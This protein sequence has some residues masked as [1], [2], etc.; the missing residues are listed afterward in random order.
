MKRLFTVFLVFAVLMG[1]ITCNADDND[2]AVSID[3]EEDEN[4]LVVEDFEEPVEEV[5]FLLGG[6]LPGEVDLSLEEDTFFDLGGGEIDLFTPEAQEDVETKEIEATNIAN[7][8]VSNG[9]KCP[10]SVFYV[11]L[12]DRHTSEPYGG[13]IPLRDIS[14]SSNTTAHL[15]Q[16]YWSEYSDIMAIY[17]GSVYDYHDSYSGGA[18]MYIV[19][20]HNIDGFIFYSEYQHLSSIEPTYKTKGQAVQAGAKIATKGGSGYGRSDG[21]GQHL[22]LIIASGISRTGQLWTSQFSKYT[23]EYGKEDTYGVNEKSERSFFIINGVTY[24]NPEKILN[25]NYIIGPRITNISLNE[26]TVSISEQKKLSPVF[27]PSNTAY[28]TVAWST[29]D[30]EICEITNDGVLK[31]KKD[32]K[33]T[34]TCAAL[35]GSGVT[36]SCVISV[37]RLQLNKENLDMYIGQTFTLEGEIGKANVDCSFKSSNSK[38]VSVD[39]KGKLTAKKAGSAKISVT[40]SKNRGTATCV[41]T[42]HPKPTKVSIKQGA[43]KT[44]NIGDSLALSITYAPKNAL[45]KVTWSS[46]NK[47]VAKVSS[48]GKVTAI[49]EGTA[50]ISAKVSG[51]K[52]GGSS[53]Q[54]IKITVTDPNKPTGISISSPSKTVEMG[55]TMQLSATLKPKTA[56]SDVS[57]KS[58]NTKIA[59]VSKKGVVTPV[60]VG[61]VTITATASKKSPK[62][63]VVSATIKITVKKSTAPSSISVGTA[64]KTL[65]VGD[66]WQ[67]DYR[68]KPAGAKASLTF[69][70]SDEAVATV[71]EKGVITANATGSATITVVTQNNKKA[72]C[73]VTVLAEASG[74]QLD[75]ESLSLNVGDTYQL[76]CFVSHGLSGSVT[77]SSSNAAVAT[78]DANALITAVGVGEA[79][80]TAS[81][82]NGAIATC[83]VTVNEQINTG[84]FE[85][86]NSVLMKY[87]GAGGDVVIPDGVTRIGEN[88]FEGCDSLIR[89]T[90]SDSVTSIGKWAFM[91]CDNLTNVIIPKSVTRIEDRAFVS[92]KS[93]TS[94]EIPDSLKTIEDYT[95]YGCESLTNV[96]IPNSIT[97]IGECAFTWCKSLTNVIIPNN[98]TSIGDNAF[99][100]CRSLTHMT[101]PNSVTSMGGWV[102]EGCSNLTSVTLPI[103][104]TAIGAL[105]FSDCTNLNSIIIPENVT[106]IGNWAFNKCESL[107]NMTI[108]SSVISIGT[109]AFWGCKNL[110]SIIVPNSV[111]DI[112]SSAFTGCENLTIYGELGSY[113]E[114]FATFW[115][116][117]FV[118]Y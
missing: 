86:E 24:Y 113:A 19:L 16:D 54:K 34:I 30:A 12:R 13:F 27:E 8:M 43:S 101:I 89:V 28:K 103:K 22:H 48:A 45:A 35:D 96:T 106:S 67:L 102:F 9:E 63:K 82:D 53:T 10:N 52:K 107:T 58:S 5:D 50:T 109:S 40:A 42:V 11:P 4:V 81:M 49:K 39:K 2:A 68:I 114:Q 64:E 100:G 56:Q 92:C 85:I 94:V 73:K 3:V 17:D 83:A 70:S 79:T 47:K 15:A 26:D 95:F 31:P 115:G 1:S 60:K 112:A 118:A 20:Q 65:H 36:A 44:L 110:T 38:V 18:G 108:P 104:V 105:T 84:D 62:G 93:L 21:Y 37:I 99:Q 77:F 61:T 76:T 72:S 111:I 66:Q 97:C 32:G 55:E 80:I 51:M 33:V 78:I 116:I 69:S 87:I 7:D 71:N 75:K 117:R 98:V 46:S 41:V 25:G 74:L 59:K 90:I 14:E 6:D 91:Y 57:W 88:A 29:S 23:D